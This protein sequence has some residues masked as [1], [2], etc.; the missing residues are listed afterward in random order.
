MSHGMVRVET[1]IERNDISDKQVFY[2]NKMQNPCLLFVTIKFTKGILIIN[3][4][5]T[6]LNV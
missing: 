6:A 3:Y 4:Q 2:K 5:N 1:L